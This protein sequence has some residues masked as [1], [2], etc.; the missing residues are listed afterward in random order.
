MYRNSRE[1]NDQTSSTQFGI[2]ATTTTIAVGVFAYLVLQF[3]DYVDEL[4]VPCQHST[5]IV[6]GKCSCTGTPFTGE[7]CQTDGCVNG[8]V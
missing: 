4:T 3:A 1:R 6:D 2:Y 5:D 8:V 7:Y